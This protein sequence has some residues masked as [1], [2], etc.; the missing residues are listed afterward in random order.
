MEIDL[1]ELE[2]YEKQL[3]EKRR[4]KQMALSTS[5]SDKTERTI[6]E[7]DEYLD[8]LALDLKTKDEPTSTDPQRT[9]KSLDSHSTGSNDLIAN[10]CDCIHTTDSHV[11]AD[12]SHK[13]VKNV[14]PKTSL[15]LLLFGFFCIIAFVNSVRCKECIEQIR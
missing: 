15:P 4:T 5:E 13:T 10:Q 6:D 11:T 14:S 12:T 9:D 2:M 7:I 1:T 3:A 8:R